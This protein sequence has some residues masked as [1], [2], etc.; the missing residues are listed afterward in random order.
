MRRDAELPADVRKL[1]EEKRHEL[2]EQLSEV[3]D[4]VA[5]KFLNDE[6]VTAEDLR[7]S[8]CVRVGSAV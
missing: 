2:V 3:D 1:A 7:V 6:E 4:E 8:V 5:E